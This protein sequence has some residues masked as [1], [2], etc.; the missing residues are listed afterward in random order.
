MNSGQKR[1]R[2]AFTDASR[3][4]LGSL[5]ASL[6]LSSLGC[7][8]IILLLTV[9]VG[10][11]Q[12]QQPELSKTEAMPQFRVERTIIANGGELLT[13]WARP[14]DQSTTAALQTEIQNEQIPL[15]TVLRDTL[16]DARREN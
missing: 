15:L 7:S 16:G 2:P 5:A 12:A 14:V 6:T 9:T 8:L 3:L 4:A 1:K 10:R 13:I 11:A